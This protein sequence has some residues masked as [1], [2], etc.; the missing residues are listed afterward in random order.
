MDKPYIRVLGTADWHPTAYNDHS[1][2]TISD[3]ILVDA[4]PSVVTRLQEQGVDPVDIPVI[5]FTHMHADHY[6]GLAPLLLYWRVCRDGDLSGLTILGPADTV[7]EYVGRAMRFVF[8]DGGSIEK[9]VKKMPRIVGVKGQ[10]SFELADYGARYMDADHAVPG[11]SYR[12][13]HR[14]SGHSVGLSGDTRYLPGF[15]SFFQGAELLIYETS[16]GGDPLNAFNVNCRHSNASDAARVANEAQVGHLLLTH[17]FEPKRR[18]A[19]ELARAQTDIPAEWA[20]P[21]HCFSF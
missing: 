12:V 11:L 15:A 6:M 18:A 7:A 13:V 1:C 21:G 17:T 16:Y 20:L 4:C 3:E 9:N 14:A 19:V 8:E 5:L 10:G 2:Y